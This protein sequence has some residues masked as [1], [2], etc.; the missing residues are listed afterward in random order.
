MKLS[1][2]RDVRNDSGP[3][4]FPDQEKERAVILTQKKDLGLIFDPWSF[5][6]L[7]YAFFHSP[8]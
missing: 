2:Q 6:V 3:V 4:G 5:F 1:E 8:L 7:G